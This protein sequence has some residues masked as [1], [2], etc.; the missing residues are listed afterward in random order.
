MK[1]N[2]QHKPILIGALIGAIV[3]LMK[4]KFLL[5]TAL[6]AGIAFLYQQLKKQL[7]NQ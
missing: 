1:I 2:E 3:G 6:G 4:R 5:F 7:N